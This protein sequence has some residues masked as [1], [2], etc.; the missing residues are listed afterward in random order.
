MIT[1]GRCSLGEPLD[2]VHVDAMVVA[3]HA[4]GHHLEPLARHV[5]RRAVGE[6]AAGREV[7]AHEG[8]AGLHQRHEHFGVGRSAGVR[9]HVGEAAAEQLRHAL[10]RQPLG[11]VDELAAAVVAPARQPFGI[12][13]GQHRALRFE[14][15]A[16]DDVLRCDQLDLVALA[17]ELQPDR[18]GDLRVAF[19]ERGRKEVPRRLARRYRSSTLQAL[20]GRVLAHRSDSAKGWS[21]CGFRPQHLAMRGPAM[22]HRKRMNFRPRSPRSRPNADAEGLGD[23]R[24][25]DSLGP[26]RPAASARL[27]LLRVAPGLA[28]ADVELPGV[29][30]ATDDLAAAD[31]FVLAGLLRRTRPR[32][33]ALAR[34][35]P[36]A[37]AV[38]Q[39]EELAAEV[40]PHDG[41]AASV[42]TS[43][44]WGNSK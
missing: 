42:T 36:G 5:D 3:A 40:E 1:F 4:V 38:R 26:S 25:L 27:H 20:K 23:V 28:G 16:A 22:A 9:L 41:A 31:V 29:P 10:D 14:H 6:M 17:T 24:A 15:G 7:E 11:D 43:P 19:G 2:L 30:G 32:E 37:A 35:P 13:V 18:V 33:V 8:V 44:A 21:P 39:R 34:Q 12:F